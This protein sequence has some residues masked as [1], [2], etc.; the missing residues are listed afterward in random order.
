MVLRTTIR[1]RASPA[2]RR[3]VTPAD[4]LHDP[5]EPT[6]ETSNT[7]FNSPL[8]LSFHLVKPCLDY[9]KPTFSHSMHVCREPKEEGHAALSRP[10]AQPGS[11]PQEGS[12]RSGTLESSLDLVDLKRK[13]HSVVCYVICFIEKKNMYILNNIYIMQYTIDSKSY[14]TF[15]PVYKIHVKVFMLNSSY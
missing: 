3:K 15:K 6:R 1:D 4:P 14:N 13:S 9:A 7:P 11:V 5:L 2:G 12:E 8:I 10:R